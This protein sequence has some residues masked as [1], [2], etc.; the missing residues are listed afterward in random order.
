MATKKGVKEVIDTRPTLDEVKQQ[1]GRNLFVTYE[2]TEWGGLG[3]PALRPRFAGDT[4]EELQITLWEPK[5][6]AEDWLDDVRF[7]DL[8]EK[9]KGIKVWKSDVYPKKPDLKLPDDL[10]RSVTD[11]LKRNAYLIATSDYNYSPD[12]R[13]HPVQDLIQ[14]ENHDVTTSEATRWENEELYP[15]LEVVLF[16]EEKLLN[17]PEVVRDIKARLKKIETQTEHQNRRTRYDHRRS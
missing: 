15:F 9:V 6:I 7:R 3:I 16:Y 14:V 12:G 2:G 11:S 10:E 4:P 5:M 13:E 8:Y 1:T 17:R